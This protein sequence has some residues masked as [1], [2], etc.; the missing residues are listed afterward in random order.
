MA[1]VTRQVDCILQR[2]RRQGNPSQSDCSPSV[3]SCI[4]ANSPLQVV[5][6]VVGLHSNGA[7]RAGRGEDWEL[8]LGKVKTAFYM[9]LHGCCDI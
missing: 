6:S 5:S 4:V 1:V 8:K 2:R 9:D 3:G 7:V